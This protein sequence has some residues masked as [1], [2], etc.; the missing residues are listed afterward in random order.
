[1]GPEERAKLEKMPSSFN[2]WR[3][4]GDRGG[5]GLS[6]T[7]DYDKAVW[8]ARRVNPD[9]QLVLYGRVKRRDVHAFFADRKESEIVAWKVEVRRRC[10]CSRA[11]A[12]GA[13]SGFGKA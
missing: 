12:H 9:S 11:T 8:F 6:W 3:G 13:W 2:V 10:R 5:V 7:T 1:M 4:V